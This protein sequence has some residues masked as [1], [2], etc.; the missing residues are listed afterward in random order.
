MSSST[1][2]S[3]VWTR[4]LSTASNDS[5]SAIAIGADGFIYIAGVTQGNLDGQPN[6][7]GEDAF[8]SKFSSDGSR[9]WTRLIASTDVLLDGTY[10]EAANGVAIGRDGAIYVAGSIRGSVD[11]QS[12]SGGNVDAFVTKFS[13]D[14]NRAWTRLIGSSGAETAYALTVGA[15]GSIYLAGVTEGVGSLDGI[16]RNI[17]SLRYGFVTKFNP[18]GTKSWTRLISSEGVDQAYALTTGA[19]GFIYVSGVTTGS[20]NGQVNSGGVDAF[21]TKVATDGSLIWARTLGTGDCVEGKALTSA[22]DGSIYV[23]GLARGT[24]DGLASYGME[25]AFIAKYNA[26]GVKAWTRTLG[27]SAGDRAFG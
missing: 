5:A 26:N 20:L 7:G 14:G 19:D 15:D 23:A 4:L 3:T 12:F 13:S 10:R 24:L 2:A 27:T 9:I 1:T 21:L 22:S 18:D 8:L 25:D 6:A 17:S 16:P 11:G